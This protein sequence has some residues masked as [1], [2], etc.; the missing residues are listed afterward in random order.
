LQSPI[1]SISLATERVAACFKGFELTVGWQD[2]FIQESTGVSDLG[3]QGDDVNRDW[4]IAGHKLCYANSKPSSSFIK[5]G[6]LLESYELVV[7]AELG[8]ELERHGCYGFYPVMS[9]HN[10]GP[11]L[12][13]EYNSAGAWALVQNGHPVCPLP[14][15]FNPHI[16]QHFRFRKN[17]RLL[18]IQ[19][20]GF[21]LGEIEVPRE[22]SCIGLYA[23][24]CKA[25]FD[26]VRVTAIK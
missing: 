16:P 6:P 25:R 20:E 7:N 24:R 8:V 5:K 17:D 1:S 9:T 26:M 23:D 12:T 2:L 19:W 22:P 11:L 10:N 21:L 18:T 14:P 15:E 4:F 3:W 13:I